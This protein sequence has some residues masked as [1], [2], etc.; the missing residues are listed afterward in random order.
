MTGPRYNGVATVAFVAI[1]LLAGINL[2]MAVSPNFSR[3]GK[4]AS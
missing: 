1:A 3:L 2:L 4:G